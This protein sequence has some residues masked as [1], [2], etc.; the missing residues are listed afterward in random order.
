MGKGRWE[1]KQI[2]GKMDFFMR[3]QNSIKFSRLVIFYDGQKY[4]SRVEYP[5]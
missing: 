4:F 3:L 5:H 2:D 1:E